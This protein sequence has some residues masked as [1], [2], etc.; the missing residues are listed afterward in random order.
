MAETRFIRLRS[1]ATGRWCASEELRPRLV[2]EAEETGVSLTAMV[3]LILCHA[4]GIKFK[5]T[6]RPGRAK[7][8]AYEINLGIQPDLDKA[9]RVKAAL[10]DRSV[11]SEIIATLSARYGLPV[12]ERAA[13]AA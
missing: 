2:A 12:P 10:N 1:P 11:Q 9:I 13:Q 5:P 7:D 3:N 4:Y 6:G 8:S